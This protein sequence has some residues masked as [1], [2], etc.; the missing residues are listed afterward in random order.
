MPPVAGAGGD[1]DDD[2]GSDVEF[3]GALNEI[4]ALSDFPHARSNCMN[5]AF[6]AGTYESR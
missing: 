1:S 3:V 5:A 6:E 2:S 4:N